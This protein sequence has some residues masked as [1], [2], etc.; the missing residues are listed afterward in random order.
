[1]VA[2][3][4][5]VDLVTLEDPE[6]VLQRAAARGGGGTGILPAL[7]ALHCYV[8]VPARAWPPDRKRRP[9]EAAGVLAA[10]VSEAVVERAWI[11]AADVP[12]ETAWVL[13][14]FA[15]ARTARTGAAQVVMIIAPAL[16][17]ALP[18][19]RAKLGVLVAEARLAAPAPAPAPAAQPPAEPT[20]TREERK[21]RK[22]REWLQR[23]RAAQRSGAS[24]KSQPK[25]KPRPPTPAAPA[26]PVPLP[27]AASLDA[28]LEQRVRELVRAEIRAELAKTLGELVGK[29][30]AA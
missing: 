20:E 22:K 21:R 6:S 27:A 29:V 30:L 15:C 24:A 10:E 5:V 28:I 19:A 3:F 2:D 13:Y 11:R 26:A 9:R 12:P 7:P 1:M 16:P 14:V 25:P 18:R 4:R 17:A 23:Q 8:P